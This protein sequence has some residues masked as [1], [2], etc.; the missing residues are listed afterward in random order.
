V[1]IF[2]TALDRYSVCV[3]VCV[4]VCVWGSVAAV[5]AAAGSRHVRHLLVALADGHVHA[6]PEGRVCMGDVEKRHVQYFNIHYYPCYITVLRYLSSSSAIFPYNPQYYRAI[7]PFI[8]MCNIP[9]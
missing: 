2:N 7:L 5:G 9:L 8:I 3:C 6:H 1:A 4:C